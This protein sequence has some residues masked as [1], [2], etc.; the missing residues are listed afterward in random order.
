MDVVLIP[1]YKRAEFLSHCIA[2]ILHAEGAGQLHYIFRMDAGHS[3]ELHEVVRGFPFSHEIAVTPRSSYAGG[4]Q[5]YS[6]LSGY[7][8]AAQRTAGKVFM[9]EEDVFV[10]TDFFRWHYAVHEAQPDLFCSIAVRNPNGP[11]PEGA[12]DEFYLTTDEYCSLGV[13]FDA[14]VLKQYVEGHATP[15]YY[16]HSAQYCRKHFPTAP[17]NPSHT[18]QDGLIRRIQWTQGMAHPIAYPCQ[19]KAYHAG[20]YGANRAD[21]PSGTLEQRIAHVAEVCYSPE[22]MRTFALHPSYYE[23]SIPVDL[24]A[25]PWQTLRLKP[26]DLERNPLRL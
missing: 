21:S 6:V 3:P 17:F 26:L 2:H 5:S 7:K 22:A 11:T 10:A 8:L 19:A 13:C 18:E 25:Q 1:C 23:D 4:K 15:A 12:H 24:N 16:V 14:Q 9:I 20:Y